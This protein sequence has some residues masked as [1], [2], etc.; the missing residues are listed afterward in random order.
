LIAE[1]VL[2]LRI[3]E[4]VLMPVFAGLVMPDVTN[5]LQLMN[6]FGVVVCG[7]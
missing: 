1:L 4:I 7:A 6:V 2:F 3:S 5:L